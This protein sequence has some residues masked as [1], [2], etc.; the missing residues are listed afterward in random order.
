MYF[1]EQKQLFPKTRDPWASTSAWVAVYTRLQLSGAQTS[2]GDV[3][4]SDLEG[5]LNSKVLWLVITQSFCLGL[6]T[7]N[8]M[9]VFTEETEVGAGDV[10]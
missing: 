8:A 7:K 4:G 1:S 10:A 3:G 5:F 9:E 2:K 6:P